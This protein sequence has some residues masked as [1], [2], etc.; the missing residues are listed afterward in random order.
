VLCHEEIRN[1][2]TRSFPVLAALL[3]VLACAPLAHAQQA[4]SSKKDKT[5]PG[6]LG[7]HYWQLVGSLPPAVNPFL[8]ET[9]CQ[10]GQQG[11]TWFL[12]STAP[13]SETVGQP[14]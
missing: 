14:H 1:E 9:K 13:L 7:A 6:D 11:P 4:H 3:A 8:D 12:Y 10:V 2:E 5:D